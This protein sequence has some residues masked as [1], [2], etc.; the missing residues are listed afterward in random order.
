M[1]CQFIKEVVVGG[2]GGKEQRARILILSSGWAM[3]TSWSPK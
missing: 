2:G 3:L 1:T